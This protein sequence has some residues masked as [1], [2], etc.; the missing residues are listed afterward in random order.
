MA[1]N[2]PPAAPKI[3]AL[4]PPGG[5]ANTVGHWLAALDNGLAELKERARRVPPEKWTAKM[6]P[7]V[8]SPAEILLH[9][10]EIETRWVHQG[11]GGGKPTAAPP[12]SANAGLDALF[13]HVDAVRATTAATL[14]PLVDR[15]LDTLRTIP[16]KDGKTTVRR[17][18]AELLEH[19]AHH[20]GQLGM[21]AK[22][23]TSSG[24]RA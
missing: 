12:P 3:R 8:R 10:A 1:T 7:N 4:L 6:A 2:A 18:L 5:F 20:R 16:G 15:D 14:K 19:Q 21:L 9:V 17:A 24:P 11:I 22:L 23:L 13:A